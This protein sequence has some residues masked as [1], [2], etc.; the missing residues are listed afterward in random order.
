M[1]GIKIYVYNC[2][3]VRFMQIYE[4]NINKKQ[5]Y[6]VDDGFLMDLNAVIKAAHNQHA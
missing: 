2:R 5:F 1:H 6:L 3:M 4:L